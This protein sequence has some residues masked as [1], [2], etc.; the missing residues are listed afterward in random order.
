[1]ETELLVGGVRD[2]QTGL[3]KILRLI[4]SDVEAKL[5]GV[6]DDEAVSTI[7]SINLQC[8]DTAD[9]QCCIQLVDERRD[10]ADR[11]I[12]NFAVLA[13]G[14]DLDQPTR[15]L[16]ND[17]GLGL[18]HR[19]D[20]GLEKHRS[21]AHRVGTRHGRSM[22]R[23]H[24]DP[25]HLRLRVL[26][27]NKEIHVAEDSASRFIEHEVPEAL[28]LRNPPCLLPDSLSRGRSHTA[29]DHIANFSLGMT[30][31]HMDNVFRAHISTSFQQGCQVSLYMGG[32]LCMN[33]SLLFHGHPS[34]TTRQCE[35]GHPECHRRLCLSQ[36]NNVIRGTQIQEFSAWI[37]RS[38]KL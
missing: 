3:N 38:T 23:L 6:H 28:I 5:V 26:R 1:M 34:A 35:V 33:A 30:T 20:P 31:H 27:R 25:S 7:R 36:R 2:L 4:W 21:D 24:D 13:A 18:P 37:A 17:P 10:V 32:T 8:A 16:E 12:G 9:L 11:H 14:R 19:D 22:S 15:R 29:H